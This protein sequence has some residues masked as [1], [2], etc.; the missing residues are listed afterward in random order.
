MSG[1]EN[2]PV[3]SPQRIWMKGASVT[4]PQDSAHQRRRS[5]QRGVALQ[6]TAG[7]Q[8]GHRTIG[9]ASNDT[10]L[11]ARCAATGRV[12]G[13][14]DRGRGAGRLARP[15]RRPARLS[16]RP[17]QQGWPRRG[18]RGESTRQER[19]APARAPASTSMT[20]TSVVARGSSRARS[21]CTRRC[22]GLPVERRYSTQAEESTRITGPVIASC[23]APPD[24]RPIRCLQGKSLPPR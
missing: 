13:P 10:S 5:G 16:L 9:L 21:S 12:A 2:R 15:A 23:G 20:I 1:S 17:D 11:A 7:K 19:P 14:G 3:C 8:G 6:A 22:A 18:Q 24:P 4:R